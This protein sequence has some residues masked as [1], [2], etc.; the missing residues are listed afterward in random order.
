[1][2]L[3]AEDLTYILKLI[4]EDRETPEERKRP[5]FRKIEQMRD[6]TRESQRLPRRKGYKFSKVTAIEPQQDE[7]IM[8]SLACGHAI[9]C[10]PQDECTAEEWA[11]RMQQDGP[12]PYVVGETRIYC[13]KVHP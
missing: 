10:F 12:S 4:S 1:M 6:T 2:G 11:R 5:V 8:I 3:S 7:T 9:R 13:E